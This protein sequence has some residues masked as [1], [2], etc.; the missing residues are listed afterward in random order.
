MKIVSFLYVWCFIIGK[1]TCLPGWIGHK[2]SSPCPSDYYGI[3]CGQRCKCSNKGKC[4]G[5]D[6][7]CKCSPGYMGPQCTESKNFLSVFV[8]AIPYDSERLHEDTFYK[9]CL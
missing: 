8:K 5:N 6:G 4:R 7:V 9:F 2:C 3:N 1:C